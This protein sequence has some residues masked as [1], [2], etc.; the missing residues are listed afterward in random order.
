[1]TKQDISGLISLAEAF[2]CTYDRKAGKFDYADY[3][4]WKK[5]EAAAKADL[6]R[7]LERIGAKLKT[8][9]AINVEIQLGGIRS[10]STSG[11][12]GAL[13]NWLRA[14]R[15]AQQKSKAA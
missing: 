4:A 5:R 9:P 15:Q 14:A 6:R 13:Q 8:R 2:I 10:T 12:I 1:M 11:W 7:E 3:D